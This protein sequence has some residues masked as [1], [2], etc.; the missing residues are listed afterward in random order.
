MKP[1][2]IPFTRPYLTGNEL[3]CIEKVLSSSCLGGDGFF[4]KKCERRLEE[5][6]GSPVFLTPSGTH[7]LELAF[8][9]LNLNPG[10]EVIL[11]SY[12]FSSCASAVVQM[13]LKP[14]FID[15]RK[16]T[17]NIDESLIE[18]AITRKTKALLVVHYAGV[19][20][21]M[22]K[23]M[24]IALKHGLRVVEDAAQGLNAFYREKHVGS[25]GDLGIFSF[26]HTKNITSGEGGAVIINNKKY[27][28]QVEIHR[29]KG[30]NRSLFLKGEV[31]QYGWVDRG[32]NYRMSDIL[33]AFLWSQLQ[34]LEKVTQKR[35]LICDYY[36]ENLNPISGE[37]FRL[38][39]IPPYC[40]SN[41]HI[42]YLLFKD[43]AMVLS[44]KAWLAENGIEATTH[45][46]PLHSSPGGTKFGETRSSMA[47]S[48]RV[49][50]C[51]LRLP[52]FAQMTRPAQDRVIGNVKTF[53]ERGVSERGTR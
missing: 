4:A 20:A 44:L 10:D 27:L 1:I 37:H 53:F 23:I 14:V 29:Q 50:T 48:E 21:A 2:S 30:T 6:T 25:L 47:V 3:S 43:A 13:G 31:D 34:A 46:P 5:L 36:T 7:A 18:T 38:P 16:D 28:T 39:V 42:Y 15:V 17:F 49:G 9:A 24:E 35:K 52:L 26:H 19:A 8:M 32:S 12:T 33:A 22:D 45:F 51:L 11:P 40:R 41:Y